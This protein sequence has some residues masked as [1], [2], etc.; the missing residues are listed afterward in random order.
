MNA[1]SKKRVYF[2]YGLDLFGYYYC[3]MIFLKRN[4][5]KIQKQLCTDSINL[6]LFMDKE[7][8]KKEKNYEIIII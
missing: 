1:K 2:Y 7:I 3:E 5:N 6:I 8:T 4:R